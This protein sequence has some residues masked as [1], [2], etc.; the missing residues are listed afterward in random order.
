MLHTAAIMGLIACT[1]LGVFIA[2]ARYIARAIGGGP[3]NIPR[4]RRFL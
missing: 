3:V 2:I 1:A 4:P